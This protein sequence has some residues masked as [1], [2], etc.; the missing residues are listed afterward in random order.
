MNEQF[1]SFF[2]IWR[3]YKTLLYLNLSVILILSLTFN[4][5][6]S[7]I[8]NVKSDPINSTQQLTVRGAVTDATTGEALP[9]VNI[10]VA[11]TT[12]GTI[13]DAMGNFSLQVPNASVTLEFSFI[14]YT[15]QDV[16]LGGRTTLNVALVSVAA[17]LSE[18]VVVGYG[19]QKKITV[20]GAIM[21]V[22]T[23]DLVVS[24]SSSVSN[25]LAG[26]IT[27]ISTVQ[28]SG[29]P[30]GDDATTYIRGIGSL[31]T[32]ASLPLILVDGVERPYTQLDPNEIESITVLKDASATAVFG[33]RGA[34][35]VLIVT[36]KRG[37]EGKAKISFTTSSGIQKASRVPEFV[38]SYTHATLY[39]LCQTNDNPSAVVLFSP[40]AIEA[41]RTHSDPIIYPDTDWLSYILKPSAFQ[42]QNNLNISGGTDRVKYF[43]SLGYFRQDG[44]F[45]TFDLDNSYNYAYNR[46]NYRTNLDM[47]V[48]KTTKIALT[49]G[50]RSE[51]RNQPISSEP[52]YTIWRNIYFCQPYRGIGIVDGKHIMSDTRYIAGETRDALNGYYG[53]GFTNNTRN[54][55]NFDMDLVQKLDF[56]TKGLSFK[57]KGSYNSIYEFNKTRSNSKATYLALY[58]HDFDTSV[59]KSDKTVVYRKSGEDGIL[60]YSEAFTK[61]RDWYMESS[62]AYA[63][64]FG[65]HNVSALLLYN[66]S[67]YYYPSVNTD[68]PR[69]YV[70]LVGRL[71]YDFKSKYLLD[72]NMGYNGSEN[73]APGK[74]FG[75]FPA[76]SVG[77]VATE[78]NFMKNVP[79]ISYLKLRV[80][81]GVVGNDI[82]GSNR[83]LY[84]PNSYSANNATWAYSFGTDN[85]VYQ[86]AA[87]EGTIGNPDVGWEKSEKQNYGIEINLFKDKFGIIA[88]YFF[89]HRYDILTR[90]NTVPGVTSLSLP[91]MNIGVVDNHGYELEVRWRDKI[92]KFNY[93]INPTMSFARN[94]IIY[95]DEVIQKWDYLYQTGNP[96]N[97]PF[98]YIWDGFWSV[99]DAA[100]YKNFPD[101]SYV[102]GPGDFRYKDL[103]GDNL[104]N[105]DDRKP[106]GYPDYPEYVFGLISD[107]SFKNFS[108][109][110]LWSG[111]THVSRMYAESFLRPFGPTHGFGLMKYMADGYWTPEKGDKAT[112]FRMTFNGIENNVK[113]SSFWHK[114]ASYIRLKNVE[115]G[116]NFRTAGFLKHLG[117]SQLRV[118]TNGFDLLTFDR[119]KIFDPESIM[120]A[121]AE[122]P[123]VKM[124]NFGVNVTF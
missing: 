21:S 118:Y 97:Q 12:I 99:T 3:R 117:I 33:V 80:S 91:V 45:R 34:N 81:Y 31:S 28:Y 44:L 110:M 2:H 59:P 98:R 50:G 115:F 95:M 77:W 19:T 57:I 20:T 114:D 36:T 9:G 39:D 64:T 15:K 18:V 65:P 104:I 5:S 27:G 93:T 63:R 68:I 122:Y 16:A 74:R 60:G 70:G 22:Q 109:H 96:V 123:I 113:S 86:L 71:T 124:Y 41:F 84:L 26:R 62:L 111:A 87:T 119:I 52:Q 72:L 61:A 121:G 112:Y 37:I 78:E 38:N 49:I 73:F 43:V 76:V 102:P 92:G 24:P 35:G 1:C 54:I 32:A 7:G 4:M 69:G 51:V 17:E 13:T 66:Q 47:N 85:P 105:V 103:N 46:Y 101:A 8:G 106:Y 94:K 42:T 58:L 89:E 10:V 67:K 23:K 79:V 53:Q 120:Q 82:M 100:N 55:L 90:R 48:T 75:L 83:F 14:G 88:D 40:E 108:L 56:I 29:R 30:G 11:G 116:Y 107:M 25:T 6:A